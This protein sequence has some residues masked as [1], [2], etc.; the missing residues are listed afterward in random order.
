MR[1]FIG[2]VC[3]LALG[4]M[5]C[6]ETAGT[7]GS[8]G[9]AGMGGDGGTG[10]TTGQEFPCTEQGIRDAIAEGGGPHTFDCDGPTTV[11]TEAEIVIDND[12][13][14]DG[15]G[16]LIIDGKGEHRVL[17]V[18]Q[19]ATVTLNTITIIHGH[20]EEGGGIYN[21]GALTL[22]NS[23][24]ADNSAEHGGGI[25]SH[26][27][28]TL[29]NSTISGNDATDGGGV[30]HSLGDL[31]VTNTTV[32]GNT[33]ERGGGIHTVV[34]GTLTL[35]S[36]T[37][38]NNVAGEGRAFWGG[39]PVVIWNSLIEG[40]CEYR[41]SAHPRG[42]NIESPGDT[43]LFQL[44]NVAPDILNLGPLQ[45]NGGPTF[46]HLPGPDSVA[47]DFIERQ[48]CIG[49]DGVPVV[50]DQRGV[51]RPNGPSCDA[52]AVEA[53]SPCEGLGCDDENVCTWNRCDP[54]ESIC[55][56]PPVPDGE[57]CD[58]DGV[59]GVCAAGG[60]VEDLCGNDPC[61][62]SNDCTDDQCDWVDGSCAN[63]PVEDGQRCFFDTGWG[64]YGGA[65]GGYCVDGVCEPDPCTGNPCDDDNPCTADSCTPPEGTCSYEKLP[66]GTSCMS[67]L[68]QCL[69]GVCDLFALCGEGRTLAETAVTAEGRLTCDIGTTFPL[70]IALKMAVLPSGAIQPGEI[71]FS[72][73]V[74]FGVDA[75]TVDKVL[76]GGIPLARIESAAATIEATMGVSDPAPVL[77]QEAPVPCIQRFESGTPALFVGPAVAATWTLDVGQTL[78]LTV[79]QFE[80]DVVV[81]SLYPFT[82]T[83]VE[84]GANCV[85]ETNSPSVRFEVQP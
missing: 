59:P 38:W 68:G 73:Q 31:T 60:C 18:R 81:P 72:L 20:H 12:V 51:E 17:N 37:L 61:D 24:V 14:L 62:D 85:W 66:D 22:T 54:V 3:V 25:R 82:L 47:I 27:P 44:A 45:H 10:G 39:G 28:L 75:E 43:C 33:A 26:G 58:F 50:F 74:E 4:L 16:N 32:S 71:D 63:T 34:E 15:E 11:V 19:G 78:E 30:F 5:G 6:S 7:G 70:G 23:T 83:T 65:P 13:I 36:S 76:S 35:I 55:S 49:A 79:Q 1:Y 9:A 46:T 48:R 80:E 64:G 41:Y 77:V 40:D 2:L 84:P 42:G 56:H 52:G 69:D 57:P 8:G 67:S 53:Q 29:M 21:A